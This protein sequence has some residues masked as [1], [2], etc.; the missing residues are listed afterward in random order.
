MESCQDEDSSLTQT[1][2]G[3]AENVLVEESGWDG[4]L[5]DC[6][7]RMMLDFNRKKWLWNASRRRFVC[8]S[9]QAS[10]KVLADNCSRWYAYTRC[11]K[12]TSSAVH[13]VNTTSTTWL[14]F[15]CM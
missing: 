4:I 8:P 7:W 9:P 11:A 1:R 12:S 13:V 10:Q 6:G 5:L 15:A 3:L 14:A 2:L